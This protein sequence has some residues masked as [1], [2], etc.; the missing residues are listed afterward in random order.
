MDVSKVRVIPAGIE[1]DTLPDES[2]FAA[3]TR[4]GFRWPTVCG[5]N[6]TCRACHLSVIEGADDLSPIL[7]FE[8]EGLDSLRGVVR[9]VGTVRLA[10]QA[11]PVGDVVVKKLGVRPPR[12]SQE[13]H[14]GDESR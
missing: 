8:Q 11:K 6:G 14:N 13:V 1:F 5:G 10:C 7:K 4:L 9:D 2:I 12:K 3:A